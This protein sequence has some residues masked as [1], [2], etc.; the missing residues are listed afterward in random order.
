MTKI[1]AALII[2]VVLYGG[3]HLFLYWENV[4]NE[5]QTAQKAASASRIVPE[6]LSGMPQ[7]L[8][9]ALQAAQ[10]NGAAGLTNFLKNYGRAIQ[11]PRKGWIE[12]DYVLLLSRENPAEAKQ[13]F[14]AVKER[15]PTNSPIYPRVKQLE[16]TY[17]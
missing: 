10:R 3:W 7:T 2:I 5:Q 4:K 8:E 11:D 6:Q 15:T 14:A 16:K 12:L 13:I 17:E 1:I 9:A